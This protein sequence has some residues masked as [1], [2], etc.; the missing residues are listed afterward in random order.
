[1]SKLALITGGSTGLGAALLRL[2]REQG[3][4]VRE[5]SRSGSGA[6]HIAC[7]F[8]DPVASAAILARSFEALAAEQRWSQLRL[9]NNAGTLQPIGPIAQTEPEAAFGHLHINLGAAIAATGLFLRIFAQQSAPRSVVN[10]SS[11]AASNPYHGWSLYCASKAGLEAFTRCVA[12][13]HADTDPP[14]SIVAIRPGII[15]TAMQTTI[16]AQDTAQ[17][18]QVAKFRQ[19]HASGQLQTPEEAARKVLAALERAGS[20]S[21]VDVRDL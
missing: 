4:Q 17:F 3:W 10:I 1:M 19:L 6:D 9:I 21:V 2:H 5:Y 7:D 15:E 8:A 12:L 20:G 18:Q 11:G 16:R 14:T 13:E